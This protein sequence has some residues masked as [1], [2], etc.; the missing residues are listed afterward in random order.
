MKARIVRI[1]NSQGSSRHA[2]LAEAGLSDDVDN[3]STRR[4]IVISRAKR[5]RVGWQEAAKASPRRERRP[6]TR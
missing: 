6:T 5:P 2:I 4:A 1:G 3:L